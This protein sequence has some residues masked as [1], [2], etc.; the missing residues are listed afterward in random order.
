MDSCLRPAILRNGLLPFILLCCFV[1]VTAAQTKP[2]LDPDALKVLKAATDT[3]SQAQSFSFHARIS[4]DRIATN[5][6]ILTYFQ[7]EQIKISRPGKMFAQ[8]DGEHH[9]VNL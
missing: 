9:D 5:G 2:D 4:R 3:I 7:D 6:Q 8:I 1:G